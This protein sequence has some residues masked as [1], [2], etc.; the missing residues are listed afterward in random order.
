MWK[1]VWNTQWPDYLQIWAPQLLK[2]IKNLESLSKL[3]LPL[4]WDT[5]IREA[6]KR[7]PKIQNVSDSEN[8]TSTDDIQVGPIGF[9]SQESLFSIQEES[10]SQEN[11]EVTFTW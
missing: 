6:L 8:E 2:Q 9:G 3:T 1:A 5:K 7:V 11:Q 4:S 10:D